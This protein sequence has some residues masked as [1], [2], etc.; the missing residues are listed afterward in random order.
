MQMSCELR[1]TPKN[2][3]AQGGL[4]T[5][6]IW[7]THNKSSQIRSAYYDGSCSTGSTEVLLLLLAPPLTCTA[8]RARSMPSTWCWLNVAMRTCTHKNGRGAG[9]QCKAAVG[10]T[11]IM[12]AA[13]SSGK[14]ARLQLFCSAACGPM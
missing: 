6:A 10:D 3:H 2:T 7:Y 12:L 14:Q 5:Q 13:L 4:A 11:A 9:D 8:L 1:S